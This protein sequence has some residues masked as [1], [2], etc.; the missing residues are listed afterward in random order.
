MNADEALKRI[1]EI[2]YAAQE[3]DEQ[4]PSLTLEELGKISILC[5]KN[6]PL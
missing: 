2:I 4:R 1:E 5:T 3:R 6:D